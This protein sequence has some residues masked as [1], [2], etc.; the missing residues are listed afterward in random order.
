MALFACKVGG[1]EGAPIENATVLTNQGNDNSGAIYSYTFN[2]DYD[3]VLICGGYNMG[4]SDTINLG[5]A[6]ILVNTTVGIRDRGKDGET[7][8]SYAG[9]WS[10]TIIAKNVKA[11]SSY[12][13]G[14]LFGL[15]FYALE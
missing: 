15:K 5:T 2:Q 4:Y 6:D 7:Q 3:L 13:T 8:Y 1:S 9:G 10:R 11:G 12:S 14:Y